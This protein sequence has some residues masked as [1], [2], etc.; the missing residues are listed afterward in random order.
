MGQNCKKSQ[1]LEGG[2]VF[3]LVRGPKSQLHETQGAKTAIKPI[4]YKVFYL[5]NK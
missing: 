5:L 4:F 1:Y 3:Y 2:F